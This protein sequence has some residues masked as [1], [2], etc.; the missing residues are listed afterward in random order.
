[1]NICF[2]QAVRNKRRFGR[3]ETLRELRFSVD[4]LRNCY[5]KHLRKKVRLFLLALGLRF[6]VDFSNVSRYGHVVNLGS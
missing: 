2:G 4:V 3:A 5:A 6:T 1:L